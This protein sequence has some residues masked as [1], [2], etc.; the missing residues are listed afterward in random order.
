MEGNEGFYYSSYDKPKGS[1]LSAKTDQ[2][3]LYFHT[4][5][6]PQKNDILIFGGTIQEKHRY[7]GVPSLMMKGI[8][9]FQLRFQLLETSYS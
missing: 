2:H 9:S 5:G 8:Y 4:L 6:T 7:V 3:K 1:E